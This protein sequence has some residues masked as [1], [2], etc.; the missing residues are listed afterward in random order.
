[1]GFGRVHIF[2]LTCKIKYVLGN[3]EPCILVIK[4]CS[5]LDTNTG[6]ELVP[7]LGAGVELTEPEL[8]LVEVIQLGA[9][10]DVTVTCDVCRLLRSQHKLELRLLEPGTACNDTI[11]CY[12]AHRDK[13]CKP[14]P[15]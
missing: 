1:M 15:E 6:R 12:H 5:D 11:L 10:P 2:P 4:M 9:H 3:L 7:L 14:H 13:Y 8:D